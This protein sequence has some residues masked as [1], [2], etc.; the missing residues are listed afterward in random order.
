MRRMDDHAL[1]ERLRARLHQRDE[2]DVAPQ[3][4]AAIQQRRRWDPWRRAGRG[5][6]L[7]LLAL[8]VILV[9]RV[10]DRQPTLDRPP[11]RIVPTVGWKLYRNQREG[12]QLRYPPGW[13]T[14]RSSTEPTPSIFLYPPGIRP[15]KGRYEADFYLDA[16]LS[17]MPRGERSF[18]SASWTERRRPDG[19]VVQRA[20][21]ARSDWRSVTYTIPWSGGRWLTGTVGTHDRALWARYGTLGEA[22][23]ATLDRAG[24][25]PTANVALPA[26]P[27]CL[28]ALRFR[29]EFG[30]ALGQLTGYTS[31]LVELQAGG[32]CLDATEITVTLED[33]QGRRL[34]VDGNPARTTVTIDPSDDPPVRQPRG[35]WRWTNWCGGQGPFRFVIAI[36]SGGRMVGQRTV[37]L[38]GNPRGNGPPCLNQALPSK[39]VALAGSKLGP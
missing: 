18:A 11:D 24:A 9:P 22:I 12:W 13:T 10:V 7:A 25:A 16:Q 32:R 3:L 39:L 28:Q 20:E 15:V 27:R 6:A 34:A 2:P 23:L 8:A 21:Q 14:L 30:S 33:E 1:G 29:L 5:L 35:G 37:D 19:L 26:V 17:I 4:W 31:G 38:V 36:R